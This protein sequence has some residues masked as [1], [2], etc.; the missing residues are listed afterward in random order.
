MVEPSLKVTTAAL[1]EFLLRKVDPASLLVTDECRAYRTIRQ[2]M[3]H[4]TT[5]RGKQHS[6]GLTHTNTIEE[7]WSL[8]KH[9]QFTIDTQNLDTHGWW[10]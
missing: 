8:L 5:D 4:A 2:D 3:R 10:G 6:D 1:R 9:S 7:F